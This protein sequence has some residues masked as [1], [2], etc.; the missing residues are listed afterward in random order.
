M[1]I[2]FFF[3]PK[4]QQT[5]FEPL[6]STNMTNNDDNNFLNTMQSGVQLLFPDFMF[7]CNGHVTGIE[8]LVQR[9]NHTLTRSLF[10]QVWE[11][12]EHSYRI[13]TITKILSNTNTTDTYE[14]VSKSLNISVG[15]GDIIG[16]Y[17]A[18]TVVKAP[19]ERPLTPLYSTVDNN[20]INAST[21]YQANA[22]FPPCDAFLC[23]SEFQ[24][25]N[26]IKYKLE[27]N[28]K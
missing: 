28:C 9:A 12:N 3:S 15:P 14:R 5:C 17:V 23:S 11:P 22:E 4:D 8:I 26:N 2:D 10:F 16:M 18:H 24:L 13:K 20:S 25:L 21:V 27:V 19:Y 7:K 6:M 1:N